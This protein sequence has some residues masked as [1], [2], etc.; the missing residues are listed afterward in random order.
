MVSKSVMLSFVRPFFLSTFQ[1]DFLVLNISFH[2]IFNSYC[3]ALCA[4]ANISSYRNKSKILRKRSQ[5]VNNFSYTNNNNN[6][7]LHY[8]FKCNSQVL[9]FEGIY[10]EKHTYTHTYIQVHIITYMFITLKN[11]FK[12]VLVFK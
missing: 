6:T 1:F 2:F 11:L 9:H 10:I 12:A 4:F 5:F 3:L 7:L 8:Y